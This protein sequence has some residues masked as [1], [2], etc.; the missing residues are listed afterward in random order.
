VHLN[1]LDIESDHHEHLTSHPTWHTCDSVG[2]RF[3]QLP[4][5]SRISGP[6]TSCPSSPVTCYW[7]HWWLPKL[8]EWLRY[9]LNGCHALTCLAVAV[10]L[11][12]SKPLGHRIEVLVQLGLHLFQGGC[13]N[14]FV[15]PA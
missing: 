9:G 6:G 5:P 13:D 4:F 2:G 10:I 1:L 14:L 7:L 11:C 12:S 3:G 15:Q 8:W